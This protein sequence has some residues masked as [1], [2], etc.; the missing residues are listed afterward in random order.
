MRRVS[1]TT[2]AFASERDDT[3]AHPLIDRVLKVKR[4]FRVSY[5]TVPY[6]LVQTARASRNIWPIF[7]G[8]RVRR[9][10]KTLSKADGPNP[11]QSE[12]ILLELEPSGRTGGHLRI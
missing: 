4:M 7:Q 5:E 3:S 8:Q 10:G 1:S 11:L 6:R 12:R 9:F 2:P